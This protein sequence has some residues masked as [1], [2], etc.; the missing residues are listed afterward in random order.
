MFLS[1]LTPK[2]YVALTGTSSLISG[3]ILVT[4]SSCFWIEDFNLDFSDVEI[5]IFC[6]YLSGGTSGSMGLHS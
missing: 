3:M 4:P 1:T 6:R 2:F 5:N